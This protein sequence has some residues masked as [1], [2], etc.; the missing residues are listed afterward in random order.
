MSIDRVLVVAAVAVG[1]ALAQEGKPK[2]L[3][4]V[5]A[6]RN[7]GA[8]VTIPRDAVKVDDLTWRHT[9]A[10]GKVWIYRKTAFGL[11]KFDEQVEARKRGPDRDERATK[12][13][14]L[15]DKVR[16]SRPT[17]MGISTWTKAKSE[18]TD[19]ERK[20]LEQV[21]KPVTSEAK[22]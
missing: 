19:D 17:A 4:P 5:A 8:V 11:A 18:L 15:G 7:P 1:S 10:D 13:V 16:F 20:L 3:P 21:S 9:A 2:L 22:P 6:K 14:D 12:V